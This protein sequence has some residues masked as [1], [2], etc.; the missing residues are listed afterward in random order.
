MSQGQ[1]RKCKL[2][3]ERRIYLSVVKQHPVAL[4]AV[5]GPMAVSVRLLVEHSTSVLSGS[6]ETNRYIK[7]LFPGEDFCG[8]RQSIISAHPKDVTIKMLRS[9]RGVISLTNQVRSLRMIQ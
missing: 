9:K 4:L 2:R 6:M 7:E 3:Y 1:F 8:Q 5:P